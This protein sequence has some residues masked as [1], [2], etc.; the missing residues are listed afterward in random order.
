MKICT[1]M[2]MLILSV[3]H[4]WNTLEYLTISNR[5]F[6]ARIARQLYFVFINSRINYDIDVYGH[7][8]GEHLSKLQTLQNKLLKRLLKLDRHTFTNQLHHDLL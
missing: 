2:R 4:W 3:L 8:A 5:F 6:N 1:G 7:C